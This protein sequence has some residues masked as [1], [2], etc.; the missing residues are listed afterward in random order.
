M[1]K[2]LPEKYRSLLKSRPVIY[3][4]IL[5]FLALMTFCFSV[6]RSAHF[7]WNARDVSELQ[8]QQFAVYDNVSRP[9]RILS[10]QDES[11]ISD[12]LGSIEKLQP[13]QAP[14]EPAAGKIIILRFRRQSDN[15][16]SA[17]QLMIIPEKQDQ[18]K[19]RKEYIVSLLRDAAWFELGDYDGPELGEL[20]DAT[21][22]PPRPAM[23]KP[24]GASQKK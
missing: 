8:I 12:I 16:W 9:Q 23:P 21:V 4:A 17:Y 1:L 14:R 18:G 5:I 22:A 10:I 19:K 13:Q 6:V 7:D 20:L 24:A 3:S 2:F 11:L 15:Q